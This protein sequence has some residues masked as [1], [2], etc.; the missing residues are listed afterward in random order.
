MRYVIIVDAGIKIENGYPIYEQAMQNNV[1][2]KSKNSSLPAVGKVWPG[3]VH[4]V[5][6]YNPSSDAFWSE[7]IHDF[8]QSIPFDGIWLGKYSL[9]SLILSFPS[10]PSPFLSPS[11]SFPLSLLPLPLFLLPSIPPCFYLS[12][13]AVFPL[14][15]SLLLFHGAN[16]IYKMEYENELLNK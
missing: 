9:P 1:F 6:F 3:P 14:P 10:L 8:H 11:F 5:D 15:H 12:L 2:V 4:F 7:C 13:G 16:V